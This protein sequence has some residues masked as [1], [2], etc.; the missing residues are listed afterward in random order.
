MCQMKKRKLQR[1]SDSIACNVQ[2][3]ADGRAIENFL[4]EQKY[5]KQTKS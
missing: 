1:R 3:I 2:G 4:P 5:S